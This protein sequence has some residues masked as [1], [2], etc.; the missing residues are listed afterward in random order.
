MPVDLETIC[1][2]AMERNPDR[3][4]QSCGELARDL[5]RYADRKP[6]SAR[7]VGPLERGARWVQRHRAL[8]AACLLVAALGIAVVVLFYQGRVERREQAQDDAILAACSGDLAGAGDALQAAE[9]HGASSS[10]VHMMRG[11]IALRS[12]RT[13]QA[14]DELEQALEVPPD[15]L[16]ERALLAIGLAKLGRG[17]RGR[18]DA[19]RSFQESESSGVFY[20]AGPTIAHAFL[21]RMKRLPSL[22]A[23]TTRID[24]ALF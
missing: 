7:R 9:S 11:Q 20:H 21:A 15:N 6:I 14:I 1:L 4:Y 18:E 10:W 8:S 5:L 22:S 3:R 12:G 17:R 23:V 19:L 2:K 16:A 24:S 13:G